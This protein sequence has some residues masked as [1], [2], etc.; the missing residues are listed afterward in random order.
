[1]GVIATIS[2][3]WVRSRTMLFAGAF[4]ALMLGT[5]L[6]GLVTLTLASAA[7]TQEMTQSIGPA[8]TVTDLRGIPYTIERDA[9]DMGGIQ[10]VLAFTGMISVFITVLVVASTFA[11]SVAL[12]GRDLGL[13]RLIGASGSQLR[14]L[15][16]TEA[17]VV[18]VPAMIAG[19]LAAIV[20]LPPALR[21]LNNTNLSP[22][23]LQARISWL[24]LILTCM[25]GLLIALL[26]AFAASRRA[27]RITPSQAMFETAVDKKPVTKSRV[28]WGL[29][30]LMAGVMMLV[31]ALQGG[32]GA[33]PLVMFGVLA[34]V[35]ALV[36]SGPLYMAFFA[37]FVAAGFAWFG[38][39]GHLA[40][41]EVKH[42]R[43]RTASLAAPILAIIATSCVVTTVLATTGTTATASE[44]EHTRAQLVATSEAGFTEQE[45]AALSNNPQVETVAPEI[46]APAIAIRSEG[47]ERVDALV[48]APV[49]YAAV[50]DV[51]TIEGTLDQSAR[52]TVLLSKEYAGW[53][54]YHA[55][56]QLAVAFFDGRIEKVTVA[57]VIDAGITTPK[58]VITPQLSGAESQPANTAL[59]KLRDDA[60]PSQIA[61]QLQTEGFQV[62]IASNW[63]SSM[64]NDQVR[65]N[66]LAA[67]ILIGP[68]VVYALIAVANT[69]VM[70]YSQRGREFAGMRLIG[71]SKRQ[72]A[73]MVVYEVSAVA[74][75][76]LLISLAVLV[77]AATVYGVALER[78]YG[79]V[80]TQI[81]W[82]IFAGLF[83]L[84]L[85]VALTTAIAAMHRQMRTSPVRLITTKE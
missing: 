59:I 38:P 51:K 39:A 56:S 58:L 48:A 17:V 43:R 57:A 71:V 47:A 2:S 41:G 50:A 5:A 22:I 33:T 42:A 85:F 74:M 77:L 49:D 36:I 20:T 19:C 75:S 76:T 66:Q 69:L 44:R 70:A 11:F 67:L 25:A 82:P 52:D 1:M 53:Y 72:I 45:I 31:L 16:L 63:F 29:L 78:T 32:E 30:L 15:I 68:A 24:P 81:T 84:C 28:I 61:N 12:R 40:H 23:P 55:G 21:L 8:V 13:L 9:V 26:G 37:G 73:A 10:S 54:G 4:I 64:T 34:L 79:I 80:V 35:T 65:L 60:N 18:G 3:R 6:V 46:H 14:R 27:S 7:H 62:T 83:G